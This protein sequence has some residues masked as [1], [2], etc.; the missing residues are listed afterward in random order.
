[1]KKIFLIVFLLM[2]FGISKELSIK[3]KD[4]F[5]LKAWIEYPKVKK[6]KYPLAIIAHQFGSNHTKWVEFAKELRKRGFVTL[7]LDLRGHGKSVYQNGKLNQITKFKSLN[8]LKSAIIKSSKSV[9]FKYI[10][11]DMATWIGFVGDK[12]KNIDTD[13]L[14]FFGASLG[15]GALISVMFDYEPK[16]SVFFSPGSV[17]EVGGEDNI[18]DV[19]IP[20][21]FVSS[22][23]DFALN[24]TIAYTKEAITPTTLILPGSGHG[25][26]L[27]KNSKKFVND[28]LD[29]YLK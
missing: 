18:G 15:G 20:I 29:K 11:Q 19:A 2:T 28:F 14:A 1:M 17:K 3:S 10:S 23:K 12:Y 13:N 25:E 22:S 9:G 24:R 16:I 27:L 6:D 5:V 8:N 7:N 21:M 26:A 4:G